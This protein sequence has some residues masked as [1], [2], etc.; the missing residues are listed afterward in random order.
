MDK[1]VREISRFFVAPPRVFPLSFCAI[2]LQMATLGLNTLKAKRR[3]ANR[4]KM[5]ASRKPAN[6]DDLSPSPLSVLAM[7]TVL[8]WFDG[9]R[10]PEFDSCL[11]FAIH[12]RENPQSENSVAPIGEQR[13][14]VSVHENP[15]ATQA[16]MTILS[17][18]LLFRRLGLP[19]LI[20]WV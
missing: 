6:M 12:I 18:S 10:P 7:L 15:P 3:T 1:R 13:R 19:F 17:L 11:N 4:S 8:D 14:D 2:E 16:A 20:L 5:R 9:A